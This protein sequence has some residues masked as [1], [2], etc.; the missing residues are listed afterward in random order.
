MKGEERFDRAVNLHLFCL[1]Y[2]WG[3]IVEKRHL[4]IKKKLRK[5]KTLLRMLSSRRFKNMGDL[6]D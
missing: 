3:K 6:V 2:G 4:Y 5:K 1:L